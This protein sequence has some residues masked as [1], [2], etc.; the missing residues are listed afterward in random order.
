M[1]MAR[2]PAV[3]PPSA[4]R[5]ASFSFVLP[6]A[7]IADIVAGTE[8]SAQEMQQCSRTGRQHGILYS[9]AQV[10]GMPYTDNVGMSQAAAA[11]S[12]PEPRT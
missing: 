8:T 2:A 11:R 4:F 1:T 3:P 12:P 5:N 7:L 10:L 6:D 9:D